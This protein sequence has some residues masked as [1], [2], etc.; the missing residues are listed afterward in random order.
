M[1]LFPSRAAQSALNRVLARRSQKLDILQ[2]LRWP[3][4]VHAGMDAAIR[5]DDLSRLHDLL[6][7]AQ[8]AL[9][10]LLRLL[11]EKLGNQRSQL[12][13]RRLVAK[14]DVD[15]GS[16]IGGGILESHQSVIGNGR[17][18]QRA[19]DDQLV[20][21]VLNGLR[22]PLDRRARWSLGFPAGAVVVQHLHR[23]EVSHEP[24]KVLEVVPE[25]V[26]LVPGPFDGQRLGDVNST[27]GLTILLDPGAVGPLLAAVPALLAEL[28]AGEEIDYGD[29]GNSGSGRGQPVPV[30]FVVA[31]RLAQEGQ[32]HEVAPHAGPNPAR[33][34][35]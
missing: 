18:G 9:D 10:L 8:I 17:I 1:S 19:P 14:V 26:D 34:P 6:E 30:V 11:A 29:T 28:L 7:A 35:G 23:L 13:S 16:P 3:C 20:G 33:G 21:P 32:V 31:H 2:A 5:V 12:P 27:G 24:G 22:L 15:F 4:R 25:P